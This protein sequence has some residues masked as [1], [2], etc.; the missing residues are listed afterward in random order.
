MN[1][2]ATVNA[3]PNGVIQNDMTINYNYVLVG[4][5]YSSINDIRYNSGKIEINT[6]NYLGVLK[7]KIANSNVLLKLDTLRDGGR[8]EYEGNEVDD[9]LYDIV[10]TIRRDGYATIY[11]EGYADR[12]AQFDL[13]FYINIEAY[14]SL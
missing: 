7:L 14:V 5:N 8:Y 2:R 10:E 13:N 9:F 11:V 6:N 1:Y 12:Y 3:A 4:G